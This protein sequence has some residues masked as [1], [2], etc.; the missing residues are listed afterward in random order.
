MKPYY[1][2]LFWSFF[3]LPQWV[4]AQAESHDF[5]RNTGKIYVVVGVVLI[6]FLGIIIYLVRLERKI[7]KIENLL[8]NE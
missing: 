6:L 7:R 8:N 4:F 3:I 5:L 1:L 2:I